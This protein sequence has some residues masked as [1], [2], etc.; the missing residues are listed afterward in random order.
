MQI[1][2]A[3][4]IVEGHQSEF[5]K[6][7][8]TFAKIEV[9]SLPIYKDEKVVGAQA[10]IR[11]VTETKRLQEYAARAQRLETAGRIAG[12]VAHDFNNLLAPIMAYPDFIRD[13]LPDDHPALEFLNDIETSAAQIADINQ[14]LLTLGRRG[15]Y[16]QEPLNLNEIVQQVVNE[17]ESPPDTLVCET[18][19]EKNLMNIMGGSSQI[20]RVISNLL[21]NARDAMQDIGRICIKTENYYIDDTSVKYERIPRGEY[22]KL[23]ISDTGCGIP[24][25]IIQKI[26]DPFFTTKKTDRKRGSGLGLSV[27]DA[28]I[29]DHNGYLD[30]S[31][32]IGKGTTFYLYFPI[33]R[34]TVDEQ[35]SEQIAGGSEA[36]LIIDDDEIQRN[37]SLRLLE[38][39]GYK[40]T[41]VESGEKAVE[42]LKENPQDLLILD[43]VMPPGIDG[44][45]TYRQVLEINPEQ[46]AIIVSGFSETE[47]VL[48]AQKLGAGAFIKK[49]LTNRTIAL[50]VRKELDREV[51]IAAH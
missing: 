28:V 23:A 13:E 21:N 16:T 12:Q 40:A 48:E 35:E 44:A 27:V 24:D 8:D 22:V 38:K 34:E 32:K 31:S 6:R 9:N 20:H 25:E 33:T 29:K 7:D 3:G 11:D 51:K 18:D 41:A 26:F 19:L 39:L 42:F 43:M 15:H 47:R 1:N 46:K 30:L 14:Q 49:P 4:K 10:I 5:L 2:S 36:V 37:V 50:A 17:L 45:E